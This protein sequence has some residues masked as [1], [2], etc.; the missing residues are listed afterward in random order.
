MKWIKNKIKK[1]C[2]KFVTGIMKF[3][4]SSDDPSVIQ[5]RK[6]L[7]E[8]MEKSQSNENSIKNI[9]WQVTNLNY[10]V[11]LIMDYYI[12]PAGAKPAVGALKQLQGEM[13]ELLLLFRNIAEKHGI[14]YWLDYGTL[15]GAVRQNGFI[16]WDSDVDVSI[17]ESDLPTLTRIMEE[18]LP[19]GY[20]F[21]PYWLDRV[22]RVR[23]KDQ[24][25]EAFLDVYPYLVYG[26]DDEGNYKIR[27]KHGGDNPR[28]KTYR[29][30]RPFPSKI[31]FP[32]SRVVFNGYEFNAPCDT[33]TYLRMKYGNY[34][35]LPKSAHAEPGH[36]ELRED[37]IFFVM[38]NA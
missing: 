35:V 22:Y 19:E 29:P 17:M 32:L 4:Y 37:I 23:K 25:S 6:E 7:R 34:H 36:P 21:V 12:D 9:R 1:L 30:H 26:Q 13:M 24:Q 27:M 18:E 31:L 33:D 5:M 2:I 11:D 14:N 3:F 20:E 8:I 16:P 28:T 10:K 15:L 38:R